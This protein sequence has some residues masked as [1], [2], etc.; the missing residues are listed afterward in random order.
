MNSEL[1]VQVEEAYSQVVDLPPDARTTFLQ[2][3]Y[4]ERPEIRREVEAL[5]QY[6]GAAER[7]V[8]STVVMT[9]AEMFADGED[10]LRGRIIAD[11]Y[12]I[13]ECLGAGGM[14]EVYLADHIAL[15]M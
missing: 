8:Q 15:Q 11:K 3:F 6:Q 1:W 13:R 10:G 14:A 2:T 5:L 4:A 12:L 9:A 7:L